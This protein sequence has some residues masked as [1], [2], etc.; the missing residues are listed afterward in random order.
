MNT[1]SFRDS[2]I[3]ASSSDLSASPTPLGM[4]SSDLNAFLHNGQTDNL[5]EHDPSN[6]DEKR[7]RRLVRN[8]E[9]ARR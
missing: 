4:S 8:R 7:N 6:F 3:H 2:G 5:S 1:A 9:A